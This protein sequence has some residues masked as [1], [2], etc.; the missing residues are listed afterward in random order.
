MTFEHDL[1]SAA[2]TLISLVEHSDAFGSCAQA[3]T[4]TR[5]STDPYQIGGPESLE[6]RCPNLAAE[7]PENL[8]LATK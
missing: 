5:S 3:A 6:D 7:G 8:K 1:K 2:A 4:R